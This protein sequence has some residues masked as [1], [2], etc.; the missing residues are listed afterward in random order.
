[1]SDIIINNSKVV[2]NNNQPNLRPKEKHFKKMWKIGGWRFFIQ[3]EL[4]KAISKR[5][6][7][8]TGLPNGVCLT[9]NHKYHVRLLI[10]VKNSCL[11]TFDNI[12]DARNAY[13]TAKQN[14][15]HNMAL[16]YYNKKLIDNKVCNALLHWTA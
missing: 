9:P 8:R 14:N 3:Q 5:I 12:D 1:M 11:G 10:G 6:T 16:E 7:K 13:K 15:V 2:I 4:N